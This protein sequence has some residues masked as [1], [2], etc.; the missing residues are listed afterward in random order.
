[1]PNSEVLLHELHHRVKNNFQIIVSLMNLKKRLMPPERRGDIRLI[2]EH[3]QSMAVAYRLVYA[4][5]EM[6]EISVGSLVHEIL[7]GLRHI[8]GVP[9]EQ[10]VVETPIPAPF[11]GLDQAIALG[12]Y[13]SVLLPPYLDDA[14]AT[15]TTLRTTLDAADGLVTVSVEPGGDKPVALDA[16]RRRL[17]QAYIGQL[18]AEAPEPLGSGPR[19]IRFTLD[20]RRHSMIPGMQ[21]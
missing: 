14:L 19:E 17:L 4:T 5:G 2:E 7:S 15:G 20:Q 16:L 1:M 11:I 18:R 12:L 3:V 13:L 21:G 6:I 9:A 10:L 8:A